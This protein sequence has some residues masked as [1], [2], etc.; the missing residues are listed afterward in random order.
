MTL[1]AAALVIGII[2]VVAVPVILREQATDWRAYDQAA[3]AL[4]AHEPLYRWTVAEDVRAVTDYPYLYPPPLA[5]IWGLG[6]SPALFAILKALSVGTM[7]AFAARAPAARWMQIALGAALVALALA[8]PAVIHDLV[9]GNVMTLYLSATA[10]VVA[11]PGRRWAAVPLGILVAI[12]LKPAIAPVL[13]WLLVA[14]RS[15]FVAALVAGLA[16]TALFALLLG[17][18]VYL[19]YLAALPKLG[20]LAQPFTGNLGLSS[21]SLV[22]ALVAIPL[23][24]VWVVWAAR[25]LDP[26]ASAA[27]AV[28]LTLI[29]QPTLGL[30]YGVF[31]VPAVAAMWFVDRRACLVLAVVIPMIALLSPPLAGILVAATATLVGLRRSANGRLSEPHPA[32][33]S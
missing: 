33:V 4:R 15:Q 20:G 1:I 8:T 31:L 16:T 2:D 13:L 25:A 32:T 28:A 10:L 17:P 14:R 26:W 22:V 9:L 3:Q 23:A 11:L 29:A 5:A 18:G 7:A 30:N 21:V 6:L 19:D 27:V 24:L 12:A